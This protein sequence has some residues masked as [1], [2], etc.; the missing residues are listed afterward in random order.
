LTPAASAASGFSPT[1]RISRPKLERWRIHHAAGTT[2]RKAIQVSPYWSKMEPI[3]P[4]PESGLTIG[5][6]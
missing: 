4:S 1:A 2:S 3:S 5:M 6:G